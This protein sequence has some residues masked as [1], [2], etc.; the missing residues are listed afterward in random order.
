MRGALSVSVARACG[1]RNLDTK[2]RRSAALAPRGPRSGVLLD[3]RL[4]DDLRGPDAAAHVDLQRGAHDRSLGGH[5]GHPDP[6]LQARRERPAGDL[7]PPRDGVALTRDAGAVDLER[8]E[9]LRGPGLPNRAHRLGADE[10]RV[11]LAAPAEARLDRPALDCQ[12]V[13]V[14]VE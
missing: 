7:A 6:A 1:A 5:V 8:D 14:E 3:E 11:L 4:L 2:P 13:A 12:L 9:L 10:A